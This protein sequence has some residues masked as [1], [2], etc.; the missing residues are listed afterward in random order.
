MFV[1][2]VEE[3]L[4]T[5]RAEF[6]QQA[7]HAEIQF[8]KRIAAKMVEMMEANTAK[9]AAAVEQ[10]SA[11]AKQK[12]KWYEF[13]MCVSSN[14]LFPCPQAEAEFSVIAL[15]LREEMQQLVTT[16]D[17]ALAEAKAL[18]AR[19]S[20]RAEQYA[21]DLATHKARDEKNDLLIVKLRQDNAK[22]RL[23][24]TLLFARAV[25]MLTSA[26]TSAD[27]KVRQLTTRMVTA[28]T[29]VAQFTKVTTDIKDIL[30]ANHQE[31]LLT[32]SL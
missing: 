2:A 13:E 5:A 17:K 21:G 30:K 3:A 25:N 27:T 12:V 8:Q 26:R 7:H 4:T 11:A 24:C 22:L 10:A 15:E 18:Q 1:F 32:V 29:S 9:T 28:E 14:V 16:Y 19:A 6:A 31:Q 20:E 23:R